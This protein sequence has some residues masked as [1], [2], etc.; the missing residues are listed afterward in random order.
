[1]QTGETDKAETNP[2]ST[3]TDGVKDTM[4]NTPTPRTN[5]L[6]LELLA[7]PGQD[8]FDIATKSIIKLSDSHI[9][10]EREVAALKANSSDLHRRAQQAEAAVKKTV[11]DWQKHGG[12]CGGS[13]GRALLACECNRLTEQLRERDSKDR[14]LA[15][16][17]KAVLS[18]N[19]VP[20]IKDP[21]AKFDEPTLQS[22]FDVV[23]KLRDQL[24]AAN[25]L[26]YSSAEQLNDHVRIGVDLPKGMIIQ[27]PI[28]GTIGG[29]V[30][31]IAS[32]V[33]RT[34]EQKETK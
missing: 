17:I 9:D 8:A 29:V 13:F 12:P 15:A 11:E 3:S 5:K 20:S 26:T 22:V 7:L 25:E 4:T 23:S 34:A 16:N 31:L 33:A 27:V 14:L 2:A 30:K 6:L 10:L 1:M 24:K 28:R 19:L 18:G 21:S 32:H